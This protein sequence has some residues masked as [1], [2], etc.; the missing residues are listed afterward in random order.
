VCAGDLTA[1]AIGEA[2]QLFS[3]GDG[4][5]GLLGHGDWRGQPSPKL[6]EALRGVRVSS[7]SSVWSHSL[8]LAEDGLVYLWSE[9]YQRALLGNPCAKKELLPNPV[10]ALRGVHVGSIAAD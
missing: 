8:A 3:W 9:I 10:E 6:V 7:V 5:F 1:F 4:C 2:G